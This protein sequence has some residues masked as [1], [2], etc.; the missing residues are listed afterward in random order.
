[1]KARRSISAI[2]GLL[3]LSLSLSACNMGKSPADSENQ[4]ITTLPAVT[5]ATPQE[6]PLKAEKDA[7]KDQVMDIMA[8]DGT[9]NPSLLFEKFC[10]DYTIPGFEASND[11]AASLRRI[12]QKDGVTVQEFKDGTA[13]YSFV[14]KNHAFTVLYREKDNS[15][16][17]ARMVP[18]SGT[19]VPSIFSDYDISIEG[20]YSP[21]SQDPPKDPELTRDMLTVSDDLKTCTFSMEYMRSVA[22][23]LCES[24]GYTKEQTTAFMNGFLGSGVYNVQTNTVTFILE[25]VLEGLGQTKI[26][27][28]HSK[29][30]D[31]ADTT[32]KL[33]YTQNANGMTIPTTQEISILDVQYEGDRPVS[34]FFVSRTIVSGAKMS[35][36]G[37]VYT[38]D[39]SDVTNISITQNGFAVDK[40]S[41]S[42]TTVLGQSFRETASTAM[43]CALD[44][45]TPMLNCYVSQNDDAT[46]FLG[47]GITFQAPENVTI[48]Q[49][50]FDLADK[51]YDNT[52]S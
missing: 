12:Y 45:S 36:D 30:A 51:A 13:F 5:D 31:G 48:P 11:Y 7:V 10:G 29:D 50:I 34:A 18:L 24:L 26:T 4:E 28:T 41:Q 20:F 1:M 43:I 37:V 40:D 15:Y 47:E 19:H 49:T 38:V 32:T 6:D 42:L 27:V 16:E 14:R 52:Y 2:L 23:I 22:E 25:G 44:K 8:E 17:V 3:I 21:D 46:Q 33:E 35:V 39:S 9:Q